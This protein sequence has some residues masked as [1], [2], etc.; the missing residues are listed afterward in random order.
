MEAT[1]APFC[2]LSYAEASLQRVLV[3]PSRH[4]FHATA[5][6][7]ESVP[8]GALLLRLLTA[9]GGHAALG[10]EGCVVGRGESSPGP[11]LLWTRP[12]TRGLGAR[13]DERHG[14]FQRAGVNLAGETWPEGERQEVR[15]GDLT[16]GD[17]APRLVPWTVAQPQN[18]TTG[19]D[20]D[21]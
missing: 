2:P 3:L 20:P 8:A 19:G 11:K 21:V 1:T 4:T 15:F 7:L 13:G 9:R 6:L 16:T 10:R 18:P 14:A 5:V 17:H 12:L